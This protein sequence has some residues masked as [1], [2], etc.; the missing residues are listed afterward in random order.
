MDNNILNFLRRRV[1]TDVFDI[2][3]KKITQLSFRGTDTAIN[4]LQN[5]K[6]MEVEIINYWK[7]MD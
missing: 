7:I 5:R 4:S 1:E 3:G 6:K 2:A